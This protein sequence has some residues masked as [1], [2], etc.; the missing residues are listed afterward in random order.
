MQ[1]QGA[2]ELERRIYDLCL[3]VEK[4]MPAS[5]LATTVVVALSDAGER[6]QRLRSDLTD[7]R[8]EAALADARH[9]LAEEIDMDVWIT[10]LEARLA[11]LE[12]ERQAPPTEHDPATSSI[13]QETE[14]ERNGRLFWEEKTRIVFGK[15]W[16]FEP[17]DRYWAE[18][19]ES[20][21]E[22]FNVAAERFLAQVQPG[23]V[24]AQAS[25]DAPGQELTITAQFLRGQWEVMVQ[26]EQCIPLGYYGDHLLH[27]AVTGA[28]RFAGHMPPSTRLER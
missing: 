20:Q 1:L 27:V 22:D 21:R 11:A 6:L 2:T 16:D 3:R 14:R 5:E 4:D 23:E 17:H 12:A 8:H 25:E 18:V 26:D 15:V 19:S 28:L 24:H 7:A 9:E 13:R 10:G